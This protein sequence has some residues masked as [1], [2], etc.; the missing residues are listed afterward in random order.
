MDHPFIILVYNVAVL[1]SAVDFQTGRRFKNLLRFENVCFPVDGGGFRGGRRQSGSRHHQNKPYEEN[2]RHCSGLP[3][4][5]VSAV[6]S[7]FY[8]HSHCHSHPP[9]SLKKIGQF[10]FFF[11]FWVSLEMKQNC[12]DEREGK[13]KE[14]ERE[15]HKS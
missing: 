1:S 3:F 13:K 6:S 5:S 11:L 14:R 15:K 12:E 10:F 2:C 7:S 9:Q 4:P 8:T